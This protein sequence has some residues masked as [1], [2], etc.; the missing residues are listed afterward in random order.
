MH[1]HFLLVLLHELIHRQPLLGC[2]SDEVVDVC[3][4][5]GL[6]SCSALLSEGGPVVVKSFLGHFFD[7]PALAANIEGLK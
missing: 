1:T 4:D 3:I 5:V 2:G 7:A 6:R